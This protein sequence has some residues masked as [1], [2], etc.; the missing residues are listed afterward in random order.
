MSANFLFICSDIADLSFFV[1][2]FLFFPC[3]SF[4]LTF[5]SSG[6]RARTSCLSL[7]EESAAVDGFPSLVTDHGRFVHG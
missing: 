2:L 7:F 5:P 4:L 1:L 3:F 6:L